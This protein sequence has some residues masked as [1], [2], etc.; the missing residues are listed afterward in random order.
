MCVDCTWHQRLAFLQGGHTL[1]ESMQHCMT[2]RRHSLLWRCLML[3]HLRQ[4]NPL[5]ELMVA[6]RHRSTKKTLSVRTCNLI[7]QRRQFFLK[8]QILEGWRNRNTKDTLLRRQ[9]FLKLLRRQFL[10]K[11]QTLEGL[12]GICS[13]EPVRLH[14]AATVLSRVQ[15]RQMLRCY[16]LKLVEL[17]AYKRRLLALECQVMMKHRLLSKRQC[18]R[19]WKDVE[20]LRFFSGIIRRWYRLSTGILVNQSQRYAMQSLTNMYAEITTTIRQDMNLLN[21]SNASSDHYAKENRTVQFRDSASCFTP[22]VHTASLP[23]SKAPPKSKAEENEGSRSS[24]GTYEKSGKLD[25]ASEHEKSKK[26]SMQPVIARSSPS[27]NILK[28]PRVPSVLQ[29]SAASKDKMTY[30]GKT[31][32]SVKTPRVAVSSSSRPK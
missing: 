26:S 6:W 12:Q 11:R 28:S 9:F 2:A 17:C 29:S 21:A 16:F 13:Q 23:N 22:K 20:W 8:R 32:N 7:M 18:F 24:K 3:I 30:E 4:T 15:M 25:G 10:L 31:S 27:A 5:I 14:A 1:C 19:E